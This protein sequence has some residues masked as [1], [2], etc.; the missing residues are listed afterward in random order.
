M[1][2]LDWMSDQNI[3][4]TK[5]FPIFMILLKYSK[6]EKNVK[7]I[8]TPS[9]SSL[10]S[11]KLWSFYPTWYKVVFSQKWLHHG[12]ILHC[13]AAGV[14]TKHPS[15]QKSL[16]L[17]GLEPAI[18]WFVVR[19]LIHWATGPHVIKYLLSC[20]SI[21]P[22]STCNATYTVMPSHCKKCFRIWLQTMLQ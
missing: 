7:R 13:I 16:T 17:A 6:T 20:N 19:C 8:R 11:R 12:L 21:S 5:A 3:H 22:I 2:G 4:I 10:W 15:E 9:P 18:S 14:A 1:T